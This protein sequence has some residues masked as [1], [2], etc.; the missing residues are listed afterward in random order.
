[1]RTTDKS[2]RFSDAVQGECEQKVGDSSGDFIIHRGDDITAYHLC[3]VVDDHDM[4][5]TE[6]VR[7]ADLIDSTPAQI[8]LQQA[9][10]FSVPA[11]CHLPLVVKEQ[12]IKLSKQTGAQPVNP[13]RG[14]EVLFHALDFLGQSPDS[15]LR[16]CHVHDILKWAVDHWQ[17]EKIPAT[18]SVPVKTLY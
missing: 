2:I 3:V 7:G 16:G 15:G 17:P 12:G 18:N 9:L 8:Y 4:G 10:G 14:N 13:K 5:I 11:Y 1:M 6:V